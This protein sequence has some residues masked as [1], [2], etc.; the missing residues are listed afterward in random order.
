MVYQV[1]QD[2]LDKYL[3][4]SSIQIKNILPNKEILQSAT[5]YVKV[6]NEL[7]IKETE[8]EIAKKES[9]RMAALSLNSEKSINYMNAQAFMKIANGV[10]NGKVNTVILP[11]DFKGMVNIK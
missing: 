4:L 10:E 1:N 9:E 8:V 5:A 2:G 7:K 3:T 6:Q 11:A